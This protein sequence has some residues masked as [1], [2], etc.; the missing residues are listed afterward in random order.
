[1]KRFNTTILCS[2]ATALLCAPAT[3][4]F[5]NRA[6]WLGLED[7]GIRRNF[8]QGTE[9]FLDRMSYVV[10]APWWDRGL[11]RFGNEVAYRIG[12]VSSSD[13]TIE[14]H[15][16]QAIDLGDGLSFRYH[17]LQGE[18]RDARFVR[19]AVALEYATGEQTAI[20]AQGTP[21]ADKE[22]IDVS[23]GAWLFREQDNALRVMVT[24]VDAPSEKADTFEFDRAPIGLHLAGTFGDRDSHRIA[25]EI[26]SQMPFELRRLDDLSTFEMQRHIGTVTTHLRLGERDW[27]V[28]EL[29]SEYT[30]KSLRPADLSRPAVEDFDR[31]FHQARLEWWRDGD[32]PWSIGVVHTYQSEHGRRPNDPGGDLR[33]Q[34]REW[35]GIARVQVPISERFSFEPQLLAGNVKNSLFDGLAIDNDDRFE[36]KIAWNARWD[37]NQNVT[38]SIIVSTQLDELAFGGGG[39]QFVARF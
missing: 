30:E 8:G 19:N 1:M 4:Q 11:T 31:T 38:L 10:A 12:S 14:G 33:P 3:G 17:F 37:F 2:I 16:N 25:F 15:L 35:F 26:G 22:Q 36:G 5:L 34:R 9:Y 28:A 21:F 20:F 23:F 29:E 13:F 6:V 18:H 27:L 32:M 39:A 24:L 7:E